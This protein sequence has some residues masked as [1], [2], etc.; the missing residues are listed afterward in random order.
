MDGRQAACPWDVV[1]YT[2]TLIQGGSLTW[3]AAPVLVDPAAVVFIAATPSDNSRS[4]SPSTVQCAVL[5]YQATLTNVG[6]L[7]SGRADMTSTFR[8]TARAEL[9]G[10]VVQ[11][12]GVTDP[13]TPAE[14]Q[15]LNIAGEFWLLM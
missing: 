11:C 3:T 15:V 6:T 8:F 14:N 13:V 4:C 12:S 2:C 7:T 5:N 10:T 1:T 9:N